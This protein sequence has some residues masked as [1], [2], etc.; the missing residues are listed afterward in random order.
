MA[1]R[2]IVLRGG[3]VEQI[4]TPLDLFDLPSNIFVAQFIGSPQMNLFEGDIEVDGGTCFA[5]FDSGARI[6][7]TRVAQSH[8]SRRVFVGI[9][10]EHLIRSDAPEALK[11]T[12]DVIE[13]LGSQ[14]QLGLSAAGRSYIALFNERLVARP[15]QTL[16]L[17]AQPDNI[18]LFDVDTGIRIKAGG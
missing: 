9:R 8:P 11:L 4:G 7:L 3:R 13:P 14:V 1:D 12:V 6:P 10:P 18:H 16:G 2:I 17:S 5:R 15:G